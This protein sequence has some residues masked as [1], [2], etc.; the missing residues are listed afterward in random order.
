M[1]IS[2]VTMFDQN[3]SNM[4]RQQAEFMKIGTQMSTGRRVVN[5]SDD[6]QAASRAVAVSQS[7]AVTQQFMD[8]R[9]SVKNS[10]SQQESVLNSVSD[11]I[12]RAKELMVQASSDSLS[13]VDRVAVA[14]ELEGVYEN[15]I[16]QANSTDGNGRYI[17]GGYQDDTQPFSR[18]PDGS[19][20]YVP[21]EGMGAREQKI[22]ADRLMQISNS[23]HEIFRSVH[24]GASYVVEAEQGNQGTVTFSSPETLDPTADRYNHKFEV[25]FANDGDTYTVFDVT[26]NEE[27]V[28]E[29][30]Y[31]GSADIEVGG[32][33]VSLSGAAETDDV[34]SFGRAADMNSDLFKTLENVI[35]VL[36]TPAE[37]A[38]E[39]AALRNTLS[40]TMRELDNSMDN[41]L[42]IRASVGARL[43]E[44]DSLDLVAG[45]RML[46]YE[47]TLSDLVDLDYVQAAS[48]YSL[49]M[50]G[51]QAAQ[52]AFVD[53]NG[54][55]LFDYLR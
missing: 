46:A 33:K 2:T 35:S 43:N 53:I 39:R 44:L 27:V 52:K 47:Q 7:K 9:V 40:T 37:T 34:I 41:V 14:K 24:A 15:L 13:D 21:P 1:R 22:D 16:G 4:N 54:M 51:L 38:Q 50:V 26:A 42:T 11:V 12:I 36:N 49:R 20:Q 31:D 32:V 19:V 6:P 29:T 23:G 48:D 55:S 3:V 5:I 8:T 30:A 28:G 10:L 18:A 25:R 17:F 45:N